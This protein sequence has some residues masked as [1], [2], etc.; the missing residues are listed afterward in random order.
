MG[1]KVAVAELKSGDAF[2]EEALDELV[3]EVRKLIDADR[4]LDDDI[5]YPVRPAPAPDF[6]VFGIFGQVRDS[7][8]RGGHVVFGLP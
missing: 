4:S 5:R 6:R 1:V 2:G 8:E 3:R 7:V